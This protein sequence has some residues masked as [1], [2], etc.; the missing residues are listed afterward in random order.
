MLL[1]LISPLPPKLSILNE[2]NQTYYILFGKEILH[3]GGN[4]PPR[5]LYYLV[6]G[7]YQNSIR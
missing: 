4:Y 1:S 7:N 6:V 5:V 2:K 3:N